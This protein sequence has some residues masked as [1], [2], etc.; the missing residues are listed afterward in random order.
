[1]RWCNKPRDMVKL[2]PAIVGDSWSSHD[3]SSEIPVQEMVH[4]QDRD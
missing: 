4:R 3:K 2:S 1:M